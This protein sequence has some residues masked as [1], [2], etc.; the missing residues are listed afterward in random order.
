[1]SDIKAGDTVMLNSGGPVMTVDRIGPNPADAGA[2]KLAYCQW[3]EDRQLR[4]DTFPVT[5]LRHA[6]PE[7]DASTVLRG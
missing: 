7:E 3:F 4:R 6:E 1:M 2:T 5:S